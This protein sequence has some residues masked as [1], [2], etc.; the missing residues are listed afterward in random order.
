MKVCIGVLFKDGVEWR[1]F[2]VVD[3]IMVMDSIYVVEVLFI[4]RV[5]L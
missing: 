4:L 1:Y 3:L 5:L 2:I